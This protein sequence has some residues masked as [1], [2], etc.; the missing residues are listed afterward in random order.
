MSEP[1]TPDRSNGWKVW[2]LFAYAFCMTSGYVSCRTVGDGLFLHR[3]GAEKLP[4]MYLV[5]AAAVGLGTFLYGKVAA[6]RSLEYVVAATH[7]T[8]AGLTWWLEHLTRTHPDLTAPIAAVYLLAELRG[9]LGSIHFAT[10]LHEVFPDGLPAHVPA[11]SGLGS[12][13]AGMVFGVAIGLV[14]HAVGAPRL[15]EIAAAMDLAIAALLSALAT[16]L[17]KARRSGSPANDAS[18][19]PAMMET[20]P[21]LLH[22]TTKDDPAGAAATSGT[23]GHNGPGGSE[24]PAATGDLSATPRPPR[25]WRSVPRAA[26][27]IATIVVLRSFLVLLVD[28]HWKTVTDV[29]I[30]ATPSAEASLTAYFGWFYGVLF[31]LTGLT[32]LTVSGT[33]IRTLGTRRSAAVFPSAT[34]L[35]VLV[36]ALFPTRWMLWGAMTVKVMDVLRRSV[37]DHAIQL[38]YRAV[39]EPDRRWTIAVIGGWVKPTAEAIAAAV[40]I[41]HTALGHSVTWLRALIVLCCLMWLV[42]TLHRPRRKRSSNTPRAVRT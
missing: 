30:D 22:V 24:E 29:V 42:L 20:P 7:V 35:V 11:L 8:L 31:A 2:A 26:R 39:P 9:A 19:R 15:L 16:H 38:A 14:T 6:R 40:L 37:A 23:E 33:V 32:Q 18:A 27:W 28:F 3:L 21:S 17:I 36:A 13:L 25:N 10:L 4:A 34:L 5:A 12:T 41:E 1:V